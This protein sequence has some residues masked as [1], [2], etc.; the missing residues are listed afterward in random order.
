MSFVFILFTFI[1]SCA[2]PVEDID[3]TLGNLIKK[4]H[5]NGD[6]FML[7]TV[8]D[9][10]TT[11][12]FIFIGETSRMERVQWVIQRDLL[13][14]YR[15][16]ARIRGGDSPTTNPGVDNELDN[17]V[18]AYPILAHVDIRRDYN[19]QTGE[20]SNV[21]IENQ[22]DRLWH[23]RG[24]MRVD[25]GNNQV[26]IFDFIAP[27]RSV[28]NAGYFEVE[29]QLS[30][31][32][33]YT[34]RNAEGNLTYIDVLGKLFVEP[35]LEG[36][37]YTYW[38][39]AAEDCTA[40]EI[41]IRSSFS[42]APAQSQ[43]EA[44]HY[45]DQLMSR[46]GYFRTEYFTYDLQRGITDQGRRY[47]IERHNIYERSFD[48]SGAVIPIPDRTVRTIRIILSKPFPTSPALYQV[49]IETVEQWNKAAQEGIQAARESSEPIERDVFVLCEIQW[50]MM[51]LSRV[52]A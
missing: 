16:Y 22:F 5:L 9:V 37:I 2:Q 30:E 21:I 13:V 34:E 6:W 35:D 40:G 36:C 47:L 8:T 48:E 10:P 20:E 39:F 44:F 33:L 43:Y 32:A 51:T 7:Q 41:A 38:G 27:S 42:K 23:E 18:A 3:R 15:S 4:E 29:E 26:S 31:G 12:W 17:P 14:A 24:Y 45:S 46:F 19:P 1:I 25:W 49:A 11:S 50:L 28:V 52:R